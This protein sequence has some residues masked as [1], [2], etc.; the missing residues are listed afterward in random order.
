MTPVKTSIALA[1]T[2]TFMATSAMAKPPLRDVPEIDDALLMVAI[3]DDLR[4]NCDDID[5][6][7]IKAL[8]HIQGLKSKARSLGYSDEEIKAYT[9]SKDEQKR[10]RARGE[11]YLAER[12]VDRKNDAAYCTFGKQ[13]IAKGSQ[14]GV[15]LKAR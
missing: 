15:L 6:R 11:E 8:T 12:G 4:K 1:L 14:I 10:M 5:A 2:A 7:M 3:A 13:E 9:G